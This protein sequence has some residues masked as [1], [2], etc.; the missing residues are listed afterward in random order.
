MTEEHG[1]NL[2]LHRNM[3]D[4]SA[5]LNPLGMPPC[6][7]EAVLAAS[8]D[9]AHYPDP[10][11]T[12]LTEQLAL[13]EQTVPGRIVCGNGA[14][15]LIYRIA[16]ALRPR[17]ALL[18]VPAF[19][20]YA[21]ALHE[22]GCTV[23]EHLLKEENEFRLTGSI[24]PL[25]TGDTDMLILCTPNNPSGLCI[26]PGLLQSIAQRCA[27]NGIFLVC[28]ECFLTLAGQSPACSLRPY[29]RQHAVIL[30]AFTKLFAMPGLRLGYA[31]C[32][33]TETA[34]KIRQSGQYWS[35][36][37]PAQAAG[38]CALAQT[39]YVRESI[40]YIRHERAFL[41]SALRDAGVRVFPSD[42]NF[43]LLKS[44]PGLAGRMQQAGILIRDCSNFR[45]LG[46]GFFRI[47]V[48]T[49][50]ENLRLLAALGRCL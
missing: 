11:C 19:G 14:A 1:G 18:C 7:R 39:D 43:L 40:A 29:L 46:T 26:S 48:R 49:H 41:E 21:A 25:L 5:N 42:A 6:I 13:A 3:L 44:D 15:D 27:E 33:S 22:C 50:E 20:E 35:V 10:D 2:F 28:D 8:A 23:R 36:S 31:V 24:L 12:A 34:D 32:G 47:A 4:F 45:G 30:K 9:G 38:I 37:A 16:H 17:R